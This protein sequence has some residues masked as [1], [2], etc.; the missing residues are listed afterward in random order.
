VRPI[1]EE[2]EVVEDVPRTPPNDIIIDFLVSKNRETVEIDSKSSLD[3]SETKFPD[4]AKDVFAMWNY[5]GG[6]PLE[7]VN[8]AS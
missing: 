6:S 5:G 4:S 1:S 7:L 3:L 8:I 2:L